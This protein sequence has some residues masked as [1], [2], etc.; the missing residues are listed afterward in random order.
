MN[1]RI[2]QIIVD[3]YTLEYSILGEGTP[4]LV[5]HGGHS[6][7]L[8]EF[9]YE[10]LAKQGYCLITPSRPGYGST[11]KELGDSLERASR[12]YIALLDHEKVEKV[13][14]VAV[15]AG[16]PSGIYFASRHPERVQTLT[17]QSAVTKEWIKPGDK[18]Y[19]AAQILFRPG[20]E[21]IIWKLIGLMNNRFP[22]YMFQQMVPSFSNLPYEDVLARMKEDDI[23][24][25][26]RMNN[27]MRSG[28]GFFIDLAQ[29]GTISTQ[30]FQAITCPTLILHSPHDKAVPVEHA[31]HAKKQIPHSELVF[32]PTWG[33]LIWLGKEAGE[34]DGKM[35]E[36]LASKG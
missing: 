15:S 24:Q 2:E 22:R 21:K 13:H 33:H 34:T 6:N 29:I 12:T 25:I 10:V 5:M 17:L 36:F 30:H 9:G 19:R 35:I 28:H 14:L 3:G 4:I 27:R 1:R 31:Y 18:E 32:V 8:E 11:S 16:G 20:L 7:C 23:E 26:R